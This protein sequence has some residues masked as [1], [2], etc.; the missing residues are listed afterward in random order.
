M[1]LRLLSLLFLLA[2]VSTAAE[3]PNV[4]LFLVDDLGW[5]DLGCQGSTYYR[6]PNIDQL[7]ARG[8]RFTDAYAA[9]AV[10]SPTRASLLTGKHPAR[11]MLTQWLPAGRWNAEKHRLRE[12][13]FLRALPLEEFTL[14]EAFREGGYQTFHVGKWHLGGPPFSLPAHHG[15]DVNIGGSEHGA[16]GGY[17]FPY[18]GSW[19]LPTTTI[20]IPKQ[21]LPDGEAGEY[22]TDR[23]ADEAVRLVRSAGDKP[24][25]LYLPFYSV[26]TP[27][28]AKRE[29]IET[30]ER[31]PKSERQG[32]PAYAAMIESVDEAVGKVLEA[33]PDNTVVVFTS[34]NGGFAGATSNAPLRANK[35][36]HYEGGIRVPLIVAGPGIAAGAVSNT[37]AISHDLYPTLLELAGLPAR[38]HQHLDGRS[39]AGVLGGGAA[40]ERDALFWHYPH[41]NRHPHS[42]PASIIRKGAWKLIEFPESPDKTALYNLERDL[43]EFH[44]LAAAEPE[45]VRELAAELHRWRDEVGA[46]AMLPNPQFVAKPAGAKRK[47]HPNAPN[48]LLIVSED[49]GPELGCYGDPFVRTPV[50]DRLAANGVLCENAFVAQAGC[51]P[52]RAAFLT[53]LYPH[54]NGQLGLATWDFRMYKKDTPNLVRSLNNAGYRTGLIGKL[55]VKPKEA[56]PFDFT[57][58]GSS[59]FARKNPGEYAAK[60]AEFF[61]ASGDEAFFLSI[62]YPDAHRPFLKQVDGLPRNPL[63]AGEVKPLPYFG[64]DTPE[65]R[66]Q[67]A[68]YYNCMERLDTYIGELLAALRD[69]G[70]IDNTVIVYIGD[71]GADM[72]RGKRTSYEGGLRVPMIFAWPEQFPRGRRH[73]E[74]VSTLDLMPTLLHLARAPVPSGLPGKNL[75]QSIEDETN[76]RRFL[77]SEFHVHSAHNFYPQRAVRD[78]RYKLIHNLLPGEI[79]PGYDFT[80]KR[81][82]DGL[83]ATIEAAA[84]PVRGAYLR[85]RQPPAFELYDLEADPYEFTN[86]A[87]DP[88]HRSTL[89]KLQHALQTWRVDTKDPLLDPENLRR[90]KAEVD[91]S[92]V[93]GEPKKER[94]K[95][96]YPDT[97]FREKK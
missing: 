90:L 51:S 96:S 72:L 46:E 1:V 88:A 20:P 29:K 70:K 94:L 40:P 22:L 78:R 54:Q 64:L 43:G 25:L 35:G 12:G 61:R 84:E 76:W 68:D 44:N 97:F 81:F 6:T 3:R 59:N 71:H 58:I 89:E 24:F 8:V 67:T 21:T 14:A 23:L 11:L 55:H 93:D 85:M 86:L 10:C 47:A 95:L 82:F 56:F 32:K 16:P 37:P 65:L 5:M 26:H 91:A 4:V 75:L 79:N 31:V 66:Q 83:D 9:C 52:S 62:N 28:Q 63:T 80:N 45:R 48:I 2:S 92:F 73:R 34:D 15:F 30:Y 42:A 13:R 74:L 77:F 38:P 50:L 53:G 27:L 41:Y 69:S 18:K 39:L 87:A 36:S 17:F 49:N 33:V 19:K 57:A 60:A 7:A